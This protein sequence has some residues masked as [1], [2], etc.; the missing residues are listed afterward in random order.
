MACWK[1][2]GRGVVH[3]KRPK[4]KKRKKKG[5]PTPKREQEQQRHGCAGA[6]QARTAPCPACRRHD[7]AATT[8]VRCPDGF[9]VGIVGGGI[10]G[11]ALAAALALRGIPC[12]CFERDLS[13]HAR[14][15]GYGFT[16]QQAAPIARSFGIELPE[17]APS[18]SHFTFAADGKIIGT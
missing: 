2:N 16:L 3:L 14:R 7:P 11:M 15:Q 17:A 9:V 6:G 8:R 1:C 12:T 5:E 4:K 18:T 10:G 13:F